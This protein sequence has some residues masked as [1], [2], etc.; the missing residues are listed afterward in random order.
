MCKL[1]SKQI[2]NEP[3][4]YFCA[5]IIDKK[6]T[7]C[8][9]GYKKVPFLILVKERTESNIEKEEKREFYLSACM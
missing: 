1:S 3:I 2:L 5:R 8:H 9:L 7:Q 4:L 6:K